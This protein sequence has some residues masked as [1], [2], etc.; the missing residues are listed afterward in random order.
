MKTK[1]KLLLSLIL[2]LVCFIGMTD[3]AFAST[4]TG[5][6]L[7][8]SGSNYAV[9]A[10]V[11]VDTAPIYEVKF[12]GASAQHKQG[13]ADTTISVAG[14]ITVG[15]EATGTLTGSGNAIFAEL[16]ASFGIAFSAS[17]TIGPSVQYTIP[18]AN[19]SGIYQIYAVFPRK[20]VTEQVV[21]YDSDGRTVLSTNYVSAAPSLGNMYWTLKRVG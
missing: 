2:T 1:N 5:K 18:S 21:R 14:N 12:P 16:E 11:T 15:C 9:Y 17:L 19:P 7:L 4:M 3:Y 8:S 13:L 20:S 6:K 10:E